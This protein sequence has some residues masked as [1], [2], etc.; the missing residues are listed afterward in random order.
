MNPAPLPGEQTLAMQQRVD[1]V[2]LG[3]EACW[4][5]G[6]RPSIETTLGQ[7]AEP[8]RSALLR[9]LLTIEVAYRRIQG[10]QPNQQEYQ[11]RFPQHVELVGDVFRTLAL[12][13]AHGG[14]QPRNPQAMAGPDLKPEEAAGLR[15]TLTV[16]AGPHKGR[17]FAF[18]GH[19][20]FLV[21]R[22]QR[23]HFQLPS[24]DKYFSRIHFLVEVNPP[25]C[26]LVDMGSRNGTQV[27]GQPVMTADLNDGDRI[28]A[29]RTILRVHLERT[30]VPPAAAQ[31]TLDYHAVPETLPPQEEKASCAA[32]PATPA[33]P[34]VPPPTPLPAGSP[35][36]PATT[37]HVCGA[38][39]ILESSLPSQLAEPTRPPLC[40][41]CSEAIRNQP[42][43]I[44]GYQII[45]ELGR[46]GMGVVY[47]ALR[48]ADGALV[49]LKTITPAMT[50]SPARIER[51]LREA[52]ILRELNHPHIVTFRDMGESNGRLYLAMDFVPGTDAARLLKE[53]GGR[54]PID[55]A[56]RLVCQLLEALEYA[57]ARSFVHRD[58]KPANMLVTEVNGREV[59]KLA[60]FGLARVYQAS[61]LSGLTLLGDV[62]GTLAFISPEQITNF[63]EAKPAG[64]QYSAAASLYNLLT[65]KF[66]FDSKDKGNDLLWKILMESPV[67]IRV[68][69][70]AIPEALAQAIHRALAREPA[71]RFPDV[72]TLREALSPFGQGGMK[73]GG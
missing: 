41:N 6:Q 66:V 12:A 51:F 48:S 71:D 55:R 14:L 46:G 38:A 4:K 63:R 52:N 23:A 30:D 64:D 22:S 40:P 33:P 5:E 17:V 37:C 7:A 3:F 10:E 25:H 56:V 72:Q 54:L 49:A 11:L 44:R 57:H 19:D 59:V 15:L 47:L 20:T 42:Q 27:N 2:C 1:A 24:K 60:D 35:A 67:P 70:P 18:T 39:A 62:A 45:R 34:T 31:D 65:G 69:R 53:H 61:P 50:P 8:E 68:R 13:A 29:G 21:G 9:E 36:T 28:R 73:D 58:I 32:S 26:R 16:T 43:P